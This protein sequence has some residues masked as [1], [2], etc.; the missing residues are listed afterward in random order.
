MTKPSYREEVSLKQLIKG[1]IECPKC[2]VGL[3]VDA[4]PLIDKSRKVFVIICRKCGLNFAFYLSEG[5]SATGILEG[6]EDP[7]QT[8][9]RAAA[10]ESG[11]SGNCSD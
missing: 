3:E 4:S 7:K 5:K 6:F 2:D 9:L 10:I 1:R 11:F 8:F